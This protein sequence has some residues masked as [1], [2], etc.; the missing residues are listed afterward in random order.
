[1]NNLKINLGVILPTLNEADNLKQLIP[2]IIEV[3]TRS[4][5]NNF[6]IL[7]I[8]DQSTDDTIETIT[9]LNEKYKNVNLI[10]RKNPPSLPISIWEGIDSS[11]YDYVMWLDA[12]GSMTA[13]GID[14]MLMELNQNKNSVIIG[15]R[16]VKGGGFKGIEVDNPS[17]FSAI[18]KVYKSEDSVLAVMLSKIFNFVI[19]FV[20]D[21]GIKDV[22]SG[23]IVGKKEY[24]YKEPFE[25]A[26]YGDYFIYL[27]KDLKKK[28]VEMIEVGYV[29]ETRR[30]GLSKS[31]TSLLILLKRA[32]PY[33]KA[34]FRV[35]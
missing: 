26:S 23:F 16:F 32:Y 1:M 30:F 5:V 35:N 22:T 10:R 14:S 18:Q 8:D 11:Q 21:T 9:K 19:Y 12:D 15:S 24:F 29:C 27:I 17:F 33:F 6:E 4:N 7:V 20:L 3:I 31:G 13:K 2:E 28:N 34:A 25:I